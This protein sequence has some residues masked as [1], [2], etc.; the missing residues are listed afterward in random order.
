MFLSKI[1]K[2]FAGRSQVPSRPQ[3]PTVRP[4]LESLEARDLL[5]WS[6]VPSTLGWP[7]SVNVGFNSNARSGTATI[8]QNEVDV[9]RFVAPRS[10]TYTF[11]AGKRGSQID[12]LAG[13]FQWNGKRVA[14]NDNSN[15]T[16]DSSFT[17]YLT[18]G[19]RY[20]FAITNHTG[21]SNGGY[22]WSITG[23]PLFVNLNNNAGNGITTYASASLRGNS[24]DVYLSG[25]NRSNWSTY[26]HRVD[27][28]L[29]DRNDLPIHTG[30]WWLTFRTGG[31]FVPGIPSSDSMSRTFDVSGFDLRNLRNIYMELT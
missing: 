21:G 10:G 20:A 7:S 26:T 23:P 24:L 22:K 6:S 12:T 29:V 18:G 15:G 16:K 17:A 5:S 31:T 3:R 13:L 19:T 4:Q 9:Y 14:G 11:T 2:I 28:Y 1:T 8:S 27:V 25:L 30:S